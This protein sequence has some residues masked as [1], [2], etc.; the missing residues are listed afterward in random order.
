MKTRFAPSPTGYIHVGNCRTLLVNWLF[1]RAQKGIFLLRL[2]DTDLER[3][4]KKYERALLEDLAWLGLDYDDYIK[5]SDRMARYAEVADILKKEGHLYPC[6]ETSEELEFKRKRQ[7]AQGLPPLYDRAA[8]TLTGPQR[9]AYEKEGR[10]PHWRFLIKDEAIEWNDM[11]R[12]PLHFEGRNLSD[13]VLIREDGVVLYTFASVVDDMDTKITHIIRG[14]D[15]LTNTAVQVQVW[16]ALGLPKNT[17]TFGHLS[18]LQ[19]AEG[20]QLSKRLGTESIRDFREKGILPM[21]INSLLAKIGTSDSVQPVQ[22]LDELMTTFDIK[23]FSR[24]TPK[25]STDELQTLNEK[26][27]HHMSYEEALKQSHFPHLDKSFWEA[28][29]PNLKTLSDLSDWWFVCRGQVE[30]RISP[31]DVAFITH[32]KDRL[33]VGPWTENPWEG[34]KTLLQQTTDRKGKSLFQ[35]LRQ[36]LTGQEHGPELKTILWLMGPD[37]AHERLRGALK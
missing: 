7:A 27:I 10:K 19:G 1:T 29:R 13:P 16:E 35:P 36:A 34:W 4:E 22:T 14:E 23:K 26:L 15:H 12:G 28:V 30:T 20:S 6:Y 11:V 25:F 32:A 18:L 21:A 8:L 17:L 3:S 9:Q 2:D 5:Q 24:A 37:I 31:E 33:P